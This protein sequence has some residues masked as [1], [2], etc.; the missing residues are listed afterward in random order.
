MVQWLYIFANNYFVTGD[1]GDYDLAYDGLNLSAVI[2][3][4]RYREW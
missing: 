1:W 2:R 4:T 3:K